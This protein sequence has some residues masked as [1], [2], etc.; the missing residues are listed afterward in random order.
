MGSGFEVRMIKVCPKIQPDFLHD[1]DRGDI[2]NCCHGED[3][4][5]IFLLRKFKACLCSLGRKSLIPIGL[6]DSPAYVHA[7]RKMR[8]KGFPTQS[9]R[10]VRLSWVDRLQSSNNLFPHTACSFAPS[11]L[12]ILLLSAILKKNTSS[13]DLSSSP[14][15]WADLRLSSV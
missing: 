6:A 10:W 7:G 2:F 3:F 14:Q 5:D 15:R 4:R 12:L 9:C 11:L 13:L 1:T 8:F